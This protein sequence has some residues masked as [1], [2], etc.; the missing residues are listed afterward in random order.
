METSAGASNYDDIPTAK[1]NEPEAFIHINNSTASTPIKAKLVH[2]D[3]ARSPTDASRS[4]TGIFLQEKCFLHRFIR[5]KDASGI[6]ERPERLRAVS[7]GLAVALSRLKEEADALHRHLNKLE[8]ENDDQDQLARAL[9]QLEI[10]DA[11]PPVVTSTR[12]PTSCHLVHSEAAPDLLSHPAVRYVHG[13][14]S[15]KRESGDDYLARVRGWAEESETKIATGGS[16]IPDNFLQGDLY[17]EW[18]VETYM[19]IWT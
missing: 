3:H 6:V 14:I 5:R 19:K 18:T 4:K 17:C 15:E 10:S 8:V 2:S 12:L 11:T 9:S 16:E 13:G 1:A 7:L